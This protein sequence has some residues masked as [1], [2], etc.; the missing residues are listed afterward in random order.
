M[1]LLDTDVVSEL[2]KVASG[3]AD[4]RVT[5][6]AR[7]VPG[8]QL[9]VSVVTIHELEQGVRLAE[10]ADPARGAILRAWLDARV[11]T[12][13]EGRI[14]PVDLPVARLAASFHVPDPAPFRDALIGATAVVHG[15]TMVTRNRRDFERFGGVRILDPWR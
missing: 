7:S 6:W 10:R 11:M 5:A 14:L 13:F 3:R 2:R 1:H 15:L 8:A 4:P 12:A 9:Y